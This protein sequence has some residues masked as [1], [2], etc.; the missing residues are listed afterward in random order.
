MK[1]LSIGLVIGASLASSVGST[2]RS[3]DSRIE[4]FQSKTKEVKLGIAA[5]DQWKSLRGEAMKLSAAMQA[6]KLDANGI[7][8]FQE[9]KA[10][11]L[12]AAQE[13]RKYG[14][15][16][17]GLDKQ[18]SVMRR[19]T[20][21]QEGFLGRSQARA[22]RREQRG[23]M[24]G[25]LVASAG[26]LVGLGAILAPSIQAEEAFAGVRKVWN[27][28]EEEARKR[29]QRLFEMSTRVPVGFEGLSD[30]MAA[31]AQSN[32]P[33]ADRE[34]F[35]EDVAKMGIAFDMAADVAGAAMTGW[36][37]N[38]KL[39]QQ[40]A[41]LLGDAVNHL[42]NN[43][44]ATAPSIVEYLDRVKGIGRLAGMS[45]EEM[46]ALGAAFR[47]AKVA[48]EIAARA[49]NSLIMK[50]SSISTE[51]K[52][53]DKKLKPLG[54]SCATLGRAFKKDADKGL[55]LFLETVKKSKDP[56]GLLR[57]ILG[58]GFADEIAMLV[59]GLDG[60][61]QAMGLVSD[62]SEYAGS[63]QKEFAARSETTAMQ[64]QLLK[65]HLTRASEAIGSV[66]LP[67]ITQGTGVLGAWITKF[68][69]FA[70]RHPTV[71]RGLGA[72]AAGF[73]ALKVA[74]FAAGLGWSHIKDGGSIALDIF[75][76]LRPSI[77]GN[78]IA[79]A[80]MRGDGSLL[81]GMFAGLKGGIRSF[82]SGAVAD[83]KALQ[84]GLGLVVTFLTANPFGIALA[85][86]MAV[87]GALWLIEKYGDEMCAALKT[88][89]TSIGSAF[90][91]IGDTILGAIAEPL[92]KAVQWT[93]KLADALNKLM[94]SIGLAGSAEAAAN[95]SAGA[96]Q[97][98]SK[99]EYQSGDEYLWML[100]QKNA[101]GGFIDRPVVSW[102]GEDGPEYVVPVGSAYRERGRSLLGRAASALGMTV[103]KKDAGMGASP[104]ATIALAQ[105]EAPR[106]TDA[107]QRFPQMPPPP[108]M[109]GAGGLTIQ[110]GIHIQAAP[111]MDERS[112][113]DM[114]IRKIA[115]YDGR[116]RR[117]AYS[118]DA[119]LG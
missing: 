50:L 6:G 86:I 40:G 1:N 54:T 45:G 82:A 20:A 85:G 22:S 59:D 55:L 104:S 31:A 58:E 110:G 34:A 8:R 62:K 105:P 28:T 89:A 92:G 23:E 4:R 37:N 29:K 3:L 51:S 103:E 15:T 18:L 46:A 101:S 74:T 79:M 35:V 96:Q 32:I 100:P 90:A 77:I 73:L 53:L 71:V 61:K 12:A 119:F 24:R 112:L 106:W 97:R 10:A 94:E 111:G 113:A 26:T 72:M 75:Q 109:A 13:A 107:F 67:S 63:M 44:D 52:K 118:D 27:M 91:P 64:L 69:E 42:S 66:F 57:E 47:Q 115:D 76:R 30:I 114:V 7:R 9:L 80:R 116:R 84:T 17:K 14:L 2:F 56:I 87:V 11:T 60:Y 83:L 38:L 70:E 21:I 99:G 108:I 117:G 43:M 98:R 95:A 39:T 102:I 78:T 81:R 65:G 25:R 68:A 93:L 33:E 88:A 36:R 49:T 48:P 41:V 5:G 16:L 19:Y